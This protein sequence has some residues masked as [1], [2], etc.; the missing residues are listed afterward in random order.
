MIEHQ[1]MNIA[2]SNKTLSKHPYSTP[3]LVVFGNVAALTRSASGCNMGDNA[4]CTAFTGANDMGEAVMAS[5]QNAKENIVRIGNHP[6]GMGLYLFDYKAEYR[7]QWGQGRQFGVMAQ[8]VEMF[9]PQ[10]VCV[11]ADGYKMVN[12]AMLDIKQ[13]AH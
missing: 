3:A 8:E 10:A 9:M 13:T 7:Q 4:G 1:N 6:L 2:S 11:H 12:Y 5:D